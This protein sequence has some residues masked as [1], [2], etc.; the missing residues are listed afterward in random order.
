MTEAFGI[1]LLVVGSAEDAAQEAAARL[2][3]VAGGGHIALA[4]GSTP[5]RAYELAAGRRGDWS[6][7]DVWW[8][9]ERCVGPDDERSNFR[10]A[11]ESLLDH[12]SVLPREV[13]RIRGELGPEPA[14]AAYDTELGDRELDLVLLGL[15]PDGHTAS[16][17]PHSPALLERERSAV[18]ANPGRDPFVPR[19]TLTIPAL[20]RARVILF[21]A[22]GLDKAR[23]AARAFG[24]DPSPDTPSSL[25][26][27]SAGETIAILDQEAAAH[28][29]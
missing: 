10:L 5:R 2:A 28:L 20:S 19:V 9:D 4:G 29:A 23:A 16:L 3:A 13:H 6:G 8:G 24:A 27:S 14:A 1:R 25:V 12:L 26:R 18:A 21:L 22:T 15:G 17:F 11:R 7:C